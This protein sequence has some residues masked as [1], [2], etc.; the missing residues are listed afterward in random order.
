M[1]NLLPGEQYRTEAPL[2]S[3]PIGDARLR[4]PLPLRLLRPPVVAGSR[5]PIRLG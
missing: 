4:D 3:A 2:G 5:E 1:A